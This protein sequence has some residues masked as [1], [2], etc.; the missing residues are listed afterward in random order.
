M[1][2]PKFP[3]QQKQSADIDPVQN[4]AAIC[5]KYQAS[6][7]AISNAIVTSFRN[8]D[9]RPAILET[10]APNTFL[11]PISLFYLRVVASP[12]KPRQARKWRCHQP[13]Q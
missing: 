5:I 10:E 11:I 13:S 3:W 7:E 8:L 1:V 9:N 12:N 4:P 6:G 2:N